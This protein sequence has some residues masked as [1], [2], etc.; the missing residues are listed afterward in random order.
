MDIVQLHCHGYLH[1]VE[2]PDSMHSVQQ[3]FPQLQ[4][5]DLHHALQRS[6]ES[7]LA[8]LVTRQNL[9]F[10]PERSLHEL[11]ILQRYCGR[12]VA[13]PQHPESVKPIETTSGNRYR[14]LERKFLD[15]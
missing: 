1:N 8:C 12:N 2:P 10:L 9:I 11:Q 4:L 5:H 14:S 6:A 3:S 15:G 7:N 13:M